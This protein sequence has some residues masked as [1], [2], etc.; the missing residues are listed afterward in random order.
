[1]RQ[2]RLC[3]RASSYTSIAHCIRQNYEGDWSVIPLRSPAGERVRVR[4]DALSRT[5]PVFPPGPRFVSL[6]AAGGSPDA[7]DPGF[8][9]QGAHRP[10]SQL[11]ERHGGHPHP[12]A[13]NDAGKFQ[14]NRSVVLEGGSAWYLRLSDPHSVANRGSTDRVHMVFDANVNDWVKALFES[15]MAQAGAEA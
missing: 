15:A 7:P 9:H 11:R 4:R 5:L 13:T 2:P 14:L 6:S 12:I 3:R 1:M 10:R 8:D